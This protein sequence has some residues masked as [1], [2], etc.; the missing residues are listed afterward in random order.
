MVGET[1]SQRLG[2]TGICTSHWHFSLSIYHLDYEGRWLVVVRNGIFRYLDP[3]SY[4]GNLLYPSDQKRTTCLSSIY[5]DHL[6]AW[7]RHGIPLG[8]CSYHSLERCAS[9]DR[10]ERGA[11]RTLYLV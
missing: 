10:S 2:L 3:R 9:L 4:Y 1:P 11:A 7:P 6:A 5:L 8:F